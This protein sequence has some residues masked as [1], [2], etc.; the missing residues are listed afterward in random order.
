MTYID[1]HTH[2]YDERLMKDEQQI[3]RAI[4]AGVTRML[5]PNC[6]SS[7]IE[8]MHALSD[9]YPANCI[10]MM[11][12]HPTYVNEETYR[13]ELETVSAHLAARK[14]CAVG[15]IGL[16]YY[17]D[18]TFK[19]QQKDAFAQ[20]IGMALHYGLPIVIHSRSATQD[21]IDMVRPHISAG[22][23]GV[24]HCFGG[25]PHEA[26]QIVE[27]GF[28]LGI[29]GVVTYKN[30]ELPT[31]L[32]E[33][34]LEYILLETDAPYLAP[35]PYRGKRN[36]SSYIPVIAHKIADITG[37]SIDDVASV[38]TANAVRLFKL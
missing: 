3:E 23:T 30:T 12:L 8:G 17:W 32:A 26:K 2:L 37:R 16:D 31:I 10:P 29:G 27:L 33:T 25:T 7:T 15:E 19:E 21:C 1:T 35:V 9:K 28:F 11:G 13:Q 38:T 5:M 22:L 24:F 20:Q 6:D 14:Y 4:N 36:E 34:P 18:T